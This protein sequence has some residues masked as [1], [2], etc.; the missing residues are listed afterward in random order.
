MRMGSTQ[1]VTKTHS[2]HF[3]RFECIK[4]MISRRHIYLDQKLLCTTQPVCLCLWASLV[5]VVCLCVRQN[6]TI[7][8]F[9]TNTSI[10]RA[11]KSIFDVFDLFDFSIFI[12][13]FYSQRDEFVINWG[14]I[15]YL[16]RCA[17]NKCKIIYIYVNWA[18]I[19]GERTIQNRWKEEEK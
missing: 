13:T 2:V 10:K 5:C 18:V 1:H 9:Y 4:K 12:C 14:K 7:Q 6:E 19:I 15:L 17:T 16:Y 8:E 11:A 3:R